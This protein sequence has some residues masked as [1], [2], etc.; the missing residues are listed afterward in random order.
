MTTTTNAQ[1]QTQI[2]L[3]PY[4]DAVVQASGLDVMQA[5][6]AV[7]YGTLTYHY[8]KFPKLVPIL[9]YLGATGT[10]KSSAISQ[11]EGFVLSSSK[12][13]GS[14]FT[15]L[16]KQLNKVKVAIID[17]ADKFS[18]GRSE[19]LLQERCVEAERKQIIHVPPLQA[20]EELD[21]FGCTIIGR[22]V[23]FSDL[24][25]RNRSILI[26]TKRKLGNYYLSDVDRN[27]FARIAGEL[28]LDLSPLPMSTR[29]TD[30]WYPLVVIARACGDNSFVN[31]YV[32]LETAKGFADYLDADE[33]EDIA[34]QSL[35]AAYQ[36]LSERSK[37]D[38]DYTKNLKLPDITDACNNRLMI[39]KS[40]QWLKRVLKDMGFEFGFY[41]GYHWLK[42]NPTLVEQLSQERGYSSNI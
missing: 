32:V 31:E 35:L 8:E 20:G 42:A 30:A 26:K 17:P 12:V 13:T 15:D 40:S 36:T 22:R 24:A 14:T 7:Y 39:K 21:I 4:I 3:Q 11:M 18:G 6:V 33:P 23:S 37:Q 19:Y 10:G 29:V 25:T 34:I 28:S 2:E 1:T 38:L 9:F 41:M 27:N 16:G 5:K